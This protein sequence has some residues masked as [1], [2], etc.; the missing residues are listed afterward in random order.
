[1]EIYK[2]EK[3]Q[4]F[5]TGKQYRRRVEG[6]FQRITRRDLEEKETGC[7]RKDIRGMEEIGNIEE[8]EIKEVLKKMKNKKAAGINGILMEVWKNAGRAW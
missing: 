1:L 3:R 5:D 4:E 7:R 8:K 2:Q 6:L